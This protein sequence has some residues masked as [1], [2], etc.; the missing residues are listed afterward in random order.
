MKQKTKIIIAAIIL[1]LYLLSVISI[2]SAL[3]VN[4]DYI[5]IYPGE[6]GR[7]TIKVE[8]NENFDIEDVSVGIVLNTIA[9]A[10]EIVSLP[11]TFIGDSEKDLDDLNENDDD[12]ASFTIKPSTN[13]KPGDYNVPYIIKYTNINTDK[14]EQ[15]QGSFGLRVSA[16]TDLD[17]GVE[18]KDEIV[19][20]QG[21]LSLEIINRG[22]GDIK[23]VSVQIFPQGYELLSKDKV[24][25]GTINA[26][27]SDIVSFDVLYKTTNTALS[28]KVSY[29]DFD[30]KDQTKTVNLPV[31]VYTIEEALKIGLIKKSNTIT[32]IAVI[33]VVIVAWFIYRK[34]IRF[35][36]KRV[37]EQGR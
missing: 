15:K 36:K 33:V 20:K 6:E 26:E 8:N 12:S 19:G 30:N 13:I 11:F 35:R 34:I 37:K 1:T 31:K 9:S 2:A 18:T 23:S 3:L 25:V 5:T 29:K 4:A 7:V 21:K 27:D 14:I 17:F 24:F 32:Y 10:G 22:L 28:A 16:K